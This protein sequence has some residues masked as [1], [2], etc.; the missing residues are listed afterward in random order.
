[1]SSV[2]H[3]DILGPLWITK[4]ERFRPSGAYLFL[5][6]RYKEFRA[7]LK[8]FKAE[9]REISRALRKRQKRTMNDSGTGATVADDTESSPERT[10]NDDVKFKESSP[11]RNKKLLSLSMQRV[12]SSERGTARV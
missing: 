11:I 4:G 10:D 9:L 7:Q 8:V 12:G 5:E 2:H 3:G 1:M 6:T